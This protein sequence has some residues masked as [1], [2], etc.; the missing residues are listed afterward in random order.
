MELMI[1]VFCM[2][3][4]AGLALSLFYQYRASQL[5]RAR[6]ATYRLIGAESMALRDGAAA[7]RELP[8]ASSW[9]TNPMIRW[10]NELIGQ[11][12]LDFSPLALLAA[13]VILFAGGTTVAA[14]SLQGA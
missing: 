2:V 5:Q 11:A 7:R 8:R 10:A 6:V 3:L 4:F 12:G 1:A 9:P 14:R 13:Q